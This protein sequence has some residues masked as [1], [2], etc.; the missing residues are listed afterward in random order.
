MKGTLVRVASRPD[1]IPVLRRL[2]AYAR[3]AYRLVRD[4]RVGRWE[5]ALL[6]G[7]VGYLVSPVDLI[8]GVVPV[9]G[10]LDDLTVALWALRRAL[11]RIPAEVADEHLRAVGVT[12]DQIDADSRR[13]A[14]ATAILAGV[15]LSVAR[16]GLGW[17]GT[18]ALQSAGSLWRLW[19]KR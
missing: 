3:L 7:G 16:R 1:L 13:A 15:A 8:P 4:A 14:A 2:P 19:R 9:I 5:K 12:A 11:R 18:A 17:A 10:Q 6:W